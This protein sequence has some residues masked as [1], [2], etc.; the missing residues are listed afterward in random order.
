MANAL[1]RVRAT[2]SSQRRISE[3]TYFTASVASARSAA[4]Q[5][6]ARDIYQIRLY[7]RNWL[8]QEYLGQAYALQFLQAIRFQISA[9]VPPG[10]AIVSA[11]EADPNPERQVRL[12][13]A[14]DVLDRGGTIAD[15]MMATGMYDH[16]AYTLLL[17]GERIGALQAV[18]GALGYLEDRK[19]SWKQLMAIAGLMAVELSTALSVPVTIDRV[20]LP[21][22]R[23]NLP[24]TNPEKLAD[25]TQRLDHIAFLNQWWMVISYLG[26]FALVGLVLAWF[27]HP[28]ARDWLAHRVV[29]H[30][31]LVSSWLL[32]DALA[33]S[34]AMFATM[35]ENGVRTSDA[36]DTLRLSSTNPVVQRLWQGIAKAIAGGAGI[37]Q[38]L[39]NSGVLRADEAMAAA[40][41][42]G[43]KQL[44]GAF[45]A[46]AQNREWQAKRTAGQI[47][48]A[49]VGLTVVYIGINLALVM[50]LFKL[51]NEGLDLGMGGITQGF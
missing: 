47:V 42:N 10:K 29:R 21:W 26:A 14:I 41:T 5:D 44:G 48:Q 39:A 28:K 7:R 40:A 51:F 36:V 37:G 3:R 43:V 38:A 16:T 32:H 33:R 9:G 18:T 17:A 11:I 50:E 6:G 27:A 24:R 13:G 8:T 12:H 35:L 23:D 4:T 34:G 25:Y 46:I 45:R 49:T 1:Y 31:P 15:A 19:G 20:A 30:I 22:V 2:F